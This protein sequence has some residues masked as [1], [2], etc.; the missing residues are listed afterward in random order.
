MLANRAKECGAACLDD[1]FDSPA[2]LGARAWIAFMAIDG[3]G[4][5]K[6]TRL[7]ISLGKIT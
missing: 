7:T 4:V 6:I 3:K 2:A 5:L 1:P